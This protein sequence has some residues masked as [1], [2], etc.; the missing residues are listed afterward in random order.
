M[1]G[2]LVGI[3]IVAFVVSSDASAQ[4][5]LQQF[6]STNEFARVLATIDAIKHRKKLQCVMAIAN[7]RL[8]ECLSQKL[9]V[10][11]YVRNYASIG[12]LGNEGV[13]YG[14]LATADKKIVDQCVRDN[15]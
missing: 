2:W 7:G 5:T 3:L 8:C 6:E 4:Q 14:Q 9:P 12:S 13:E 1:L 10:D 11:T 15:P